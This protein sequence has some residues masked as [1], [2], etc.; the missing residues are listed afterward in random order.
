MIVCVCS[1]RRRKDTYRT[2]KFAGNGPGTDVRFFPLQET[3]LKDESHFDGPQSHGFGQA[4]DR[5]QQ[6][7]H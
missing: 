5:G 2:S 4:D 6:R 7:E 3:S 1:N